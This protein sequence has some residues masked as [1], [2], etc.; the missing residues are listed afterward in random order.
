MDNEGLKLEML[1]KMSFILLDIK[2]KL[3]LL[4][5]G[6][7]LTFMAVIEMVGID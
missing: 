5:L 1:S 4:Y 6:T 7:V 2:F 3:I